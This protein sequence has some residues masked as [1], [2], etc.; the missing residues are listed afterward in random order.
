M[1]TETITYTD[2]NGVK[3]TEEWRF[4]LNKAEMVELE[5]SI[6][7]GF[8]EAVKKM[9]QTQD[10]KEIYKIFK[11]ITMKA[12][13]KKSPDGKMFVK[14]QAIIDE[15]FQSEAYPEFFM[16]MLKNPEKCADFMNALAPK[17]E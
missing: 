6:D 17:G 8:T 5:V 9:Q 11:E 7:G 15:F 2:Y 3:R 12:V 14:N 1:V 13:G 4:H 16:T 10:P